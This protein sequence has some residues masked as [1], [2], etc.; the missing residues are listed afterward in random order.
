MEDWSLAMPACGS[1]R[2]MGPVMECSR[3]SSGR[4]LTG[5]ELYPGFSWKKI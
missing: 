3:A 5:M 2:Y 4:T 1:A